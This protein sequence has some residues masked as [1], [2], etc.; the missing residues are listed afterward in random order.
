MYLNVLVSLLLT[1]LDV[2]GSL[3]LGGTNFHYNF[4]NS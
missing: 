4:R 3:E 1:I 2:V